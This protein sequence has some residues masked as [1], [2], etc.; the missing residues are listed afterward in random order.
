MTDLFLIRHS[1]KMRLPITGKTAEFDLMHPLSVEGEERAKMLL[2]FPELRNADFAV[3]S[4]MSRA[5]ATLRYLIEADHVPYRIDDRLR[6]MPAW[7][8]P[9]SGDPDQPPRWPD[10][11]ERIDG[12]ESIMDCRQRMEAAI[13]DAVNAYP[14]KK[15]LVGSHGRSIGAYL[16]GILDDFGDE[17]VPNINSPDVFHLTFD[18]ETIVA[19][20]R[21]DMPFPLPARDSFHRGK[22]GPD[23][24]PPG[25]VANT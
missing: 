16:S 24:R 25:F 17:F 21:L 5:L 7:K 19:Y 4:N 3:A 23:L 2:D 20:D 22:H 11:Y 9:G 12:G 8:R 6:E 13:I 1:I 14:D 18:G 15:I 10:P